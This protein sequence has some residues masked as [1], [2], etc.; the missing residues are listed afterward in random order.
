M[1]RALLLLLLSREAK[2]LRASFRADREVGGLTGTA[3]GHHNGLIAD[4]LDDV[5]VTHRNDALPADA[6]RAATACAVGR[7]SKGVKGRT[8]SAAAKHS[9]IAVASQDPDKL[10][11]RSVTLTASPRFRKR[12]EPFDL[13]GRNH[14]GLLM[15][16]ALIVALALSGCANKPHVYSAGQGVVYDGRQYWIGEPSEEYKINWA[17]DHLRKKVFDDKERDALA[18]CE[19]GSAAD[20]G[21]T[22]VGLTVCSAL[23]E[24]NPALAW[25][26]TPVAIAVNIGASWALCQ[27]W[28]NQAEASPRA[29]SRWRD[30]ERFGRIRAA[31]GVWNLGQ[32]AGC[33]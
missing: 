5:A 25:M 3:S 16:G 11:E 29:D 15:C 26:P 9:A 33:L 1:I 20:I 8:S 24:A 18:W 12:N 23:K 14:R 6:S 21:S 22:A 7:A 27:H 28:R 19:W 32:I 10:G 4:N 31:A 2:V 30:P 13:L 17:H